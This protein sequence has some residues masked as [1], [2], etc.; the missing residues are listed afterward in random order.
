MTL[1]R[2]VVQPRDA[3]N[4]A[5]TIGNQALFDVVNWTNDS[6]AKLFLGTGPV[7]NI[8]SQGEP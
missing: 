2:S 6:W 3:A 1:S 8:H 7:Y 5:I 4:R